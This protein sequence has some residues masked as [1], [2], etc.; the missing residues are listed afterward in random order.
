MNTTIINGKSVPV[1]FLTKRQALI[2]NIIILIALF[3]PLVAFQYYNANS[4]QTLDNVV[5]LNLPGEQTLT[6]VRDVPEFKYEKAPKSQINF[7]NIKGFQERRSAK[8]KDEQ[9]IFDHSPNIP[10]SAFF[11]KFSDVEFTISSANF[12]SVAGGYPLQ[13]LR[14]QLTLKREPTSTFMELI[15]TLTLPWSIIGIILWSILFWPYTI[16]TATDEK[17]DPLGVQNGSKKAVGSF[18]RYYSLS[19][20]VQIF[21][22]IIFTLSLNYSEQLNKRFSEDF[23]KLYP[24]S[25]V[26]NFIPLN[27]KAYDYF[28][29]NPQEYDVA[30]YADNTLA[31][32][33]KA[34]H[35]KMFKKFHDFSSLISIKTGNEMN[36]EQIVDN[37]SIPTTTVQNSEAEEENR[38]YIVGGEMK[39]WLEKPPRYVSS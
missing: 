2:V 38:F 28:I 25:S 10:E 6:N 12:P 11:Y 14:T 32:N 13:R 37:L 4:L 21:G 1:S 30:I 5:T 22:I 7:S 23:E 15:R 35:W 8:F 26:D 17:N 18:M 19:A 16:F 29:F 3:I 34:G 39:I 24:L 33:I 9:R 20:V 36:S 31:G 27:P